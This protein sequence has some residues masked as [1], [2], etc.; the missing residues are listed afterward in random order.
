[1]E[2]APQIEKQLR[3]LFNLQ[4]VDSK[5]D[6][7]RSVRGELPMEVHDLEDEIIG[8]E[9]RI[10]NTMNAI[11]ELKQATETFKSKIQECNTLLLRY[12]SQQM[13]VKNNREYVAISKEMEL[14][15]LE[16]MAAEKRIKEIKAEIT[17]KEQSIEQ[18][19]Q[20]LQEKKK[21]LVEKERELSEIIAETEKEEEE[22]LRMREQATKEIEERLL[23]AYNKIRATYLNK[24]AVVPIERDACGGC[25]S[26]VPP[27]RQLDVRLHLKII[28]CENCGRILIDHDLA[29]EIKNNNS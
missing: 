24:L 2:K 13:H 22:I 8:L 17:E 12:E 15:K 21:D 14:Q 25:F 4:L 6:K 18:Y 3:A 7:L 26:Q 29:E 20:D 9:T 28:A 1:M 23:K 16:I 27:Q 19:Q 10:E 11:Q 5:I